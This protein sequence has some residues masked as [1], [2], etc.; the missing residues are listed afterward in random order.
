[1][2][3]AGGQAQMP[4]AEWNLIAR[5]VVQRPSPCSYP[6]VQSPVEIVP[7]LIR[8][9]FR[10]EA[11]TDRLKIGIPDRLHPGIVTGLISEC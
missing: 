2:A 6:A 10:Q 7:K 8:S 4:M 11:E 5:D 1:M 3:G 9:A